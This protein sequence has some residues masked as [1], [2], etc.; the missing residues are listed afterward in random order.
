ML[1]EMPVRGSVSV[2]ER[3][4]KVDDVGDIESVLRSRCPMGWRAAK[5]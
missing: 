3:C 4:C 5:T 1:S 2:Q